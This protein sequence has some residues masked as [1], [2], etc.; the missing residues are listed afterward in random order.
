MKIMKENKDKIEKKDMFIPIEVEVVSDS[1]VSST[2]E[3]SS[4]P[5]EHSVRPLH[6]APCTTHCLLE[7]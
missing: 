2:Q 5:S 1:V 6:L 4:E 7:H 3:L